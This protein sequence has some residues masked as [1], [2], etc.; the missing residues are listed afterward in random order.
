MNV[1]ELMKRFLE[2]EGF[3]YEWDEENWVFKFQGL[4]VI[5]F[6]NENHETLLSLGVAY[7]AEEI[8][9][10]VALDLCNE[11]NQTSILKHYLIDDDTLVVLFEEFIEETEVTN[12]AVMDI[13]EILVDGAHRFSKRMDE[14]TSY[15]SHPANKVVN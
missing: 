15:L 14:L 8:P 11:L 7:G 1:K 3:K 9:R 10:Y 6:L 2:E 12:E 5:L 4:K 13:L